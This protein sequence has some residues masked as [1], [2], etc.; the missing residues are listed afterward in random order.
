MWEGGPKPIHKL[1][2]GLEQACGYRGTGQVST[3]SLINQCLPPGDPVLTTPDSQQ[4]VHLAGLSQHQ[5]VFQEHKYMNE[6]F[7]SAG[8]GSCTPDILSL[9]PQ[10]NGTVHYPWGRTATFARR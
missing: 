10:K 7:E 6:G 2:P 3:A 1:G 4:L 8:T 9:I 5:F